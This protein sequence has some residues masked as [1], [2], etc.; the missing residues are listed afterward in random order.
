MFT[1]TAATRPARGSHRAVVRVP[2]LAGAG[3]TAAWLASLLAGAPNPSV[4]APGTRVVAS[5]AGRGGPAMAMFVLAEGVAAIALAVVAVVVARP[6]LHREA[7]PAARLAA[8]LSVGFGVTAAAVSWVGLALGTWLICVLAPERQ[9][10][11][12]GAAYHALMRLD[13]AKMFLLA[14]MAAA[15]ST[16]TVTVR[17]RPGGWRRRDSRS[18]R[19]WRYPASATCC[20]RPHLPTRCICPGSCC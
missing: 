15:V 8:Q 18:R 1:R 13:G 20:S 19:R 3:Y 16:M 5:F 7:R 14:V 17:L 6:A 4:S 2:V 12:A 11:T 10:G 9:S